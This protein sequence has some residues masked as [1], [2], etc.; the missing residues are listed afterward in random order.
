MKKTDYNRIVQ[1]LSYNTA[2]I[3]FVCCVNYFDCI[4]NQ[5]PLILNVYTYE[6]IIV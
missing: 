1:F 5:I 6:K 3:V 2:N 4:S